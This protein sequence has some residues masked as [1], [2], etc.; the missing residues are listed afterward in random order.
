MSDAPRVS[1][2]IIT[3]NHEDFIDEAID[4]MVRQDYPNL[5]V[6]VVDDGSTD[7]TR[8]K[9]LRYEKHGVTVHTKQNGGPS[10]A[11]N[12]GCQLATGDVLT[13]QSGDDI[14]LDGRIRAQIEHL[15]RAQ[16]D[17]VW[18]AP[19]LID[20]A[21]AALRSSLLPFF[22][23]DR[24][25]STPE[26]IFDELFYRDNFI[27]AP[28]VAMKRASWLK[29]GPFH[30]GLFQLQDYDY[31]LRAAAYRLKLSG[32]AEPCVAY[33]LHGSNLSDQ[34]NQTRTNRE[35]NYVLRAIGGQ[36]DATFLN[37][38]L[39]GCGF[40]ST[41]ERPSRILLPHLFLRHSSPDIRQIG[42]DF[43]LNL[44]KDE[45]DRCLLRQHFSITPRTVSDLLL[46]SL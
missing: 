31:W 44:M 26:A 27:C 38:V 23:K 6:I 3:Y 28:A 45:N 34:A 14:S 16:A 37:T 17:I 1:A 21:G 29:L 35:Y 10:S 25:L 22:F 19:K 2:I 4:S 41:G 46:R 5:E 12:L 42:F 24:D 40:A 13:I 15:R 30:E 7:A 8:Q 36:L 11:L 18:S 39:Y 9:A 43:L 33:R 20:N 32:N